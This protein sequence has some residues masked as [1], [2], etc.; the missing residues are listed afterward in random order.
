MSMNTDMS[1]WER[2]WV[3]KPREVILREESSQKLGRH[4]ALPDLLAIGIG[5][6]VGSGVFV[7]SGVVR[8]LFV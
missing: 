4:L 1:M 3:T 2:M 6:T 7:L 8:H 5:G